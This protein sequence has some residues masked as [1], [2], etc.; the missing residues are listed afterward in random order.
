MLLPSLQSVEERLAVAKCRICG[1]DTTLYVNGHPICLECDDEFNRE[2]EFS[3][4][5]TSTASE[6]D[7]DDSLTYQNARPR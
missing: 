7:A 4:I 3:P 1:V 6:S 5:Q 2:L